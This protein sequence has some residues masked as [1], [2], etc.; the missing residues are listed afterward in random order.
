MVSFS[1]DLDGFSLRLRVA[2]AP[3]IPRARSPMVE[4][5]SGIAAPSFA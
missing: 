5:G 2:P 4:E 1:E 3:K